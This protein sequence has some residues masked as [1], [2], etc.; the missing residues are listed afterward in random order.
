[1]KLLLVGTCQMDP[2]VD[3]CREAGISADHALMGFKKHDVFRTP[4]PSETYSACVLGFALRYAI[5][6]AS[7]INNELIFWRLDSTGKDNLKTRLL[8][9]LELKITEA[10]S[11][12]RST[13]VIVLSFIEPSRCYVGDFLQHDV[14][15]DFSEFVHQL[16]IGIAEI[17][18]RLPNTFYVD[19]NPSI[20]AI[21]RLGAQSDALSASTHASFIGDW[22]YDSDSKRIVE[23]VRPSAHFDTSDRAFRY[24][25]HLLRR[26]TNSIKSFE[27]QTVKLIIVDLDDTLWRG[28]A[29][30]DDYDTV[31]RREGWPLGFVE[32]L[33]V[34]K[35]RGGLLAICSKNEHDETLRRFKKIW[36]NVISVDDFISVKISWRPKSETISEILIEAN[37]LPENVVYVDDNPREIDEVLSRFGNLRTL[38]FNHYAWRSSIL[39]DS[40]FLTPRITD[41]SKR[42]TSLLKNK[43]ERDASANTGNREDW[44]LSLS[45]TQRI[46]PLLETH[47]PQFTRALELLNKTNQFNTTGRRWTEAEINDFISTGGHLL[48]TWLRDRNGDNGL[49]GLA[50][51]KENIIVQ[52]V[53]SC[54]VFGLDV[55]INLVRSACQRILRSFDLALGVISDTEKNFASRDIFIR[56]GFELQ[57]NGLYASTSPASAPRWI[58]LTES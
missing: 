6:E 14:E 13:P 48:A 20:E 19:V 5:E 33:L 8:N 56:C 25:Q 45:L 2:L 27:G 28:I 21:G 50:L 7:E 16:N 36:G 43:I 11:A 35:A 55:E 9:L 42:R 39:F 29:A 4:G 40:A 1:M 49:I 31:M 44:L 37:L 53:L 32:A 58:N 47:T 52:I 22:D 18:R 23:P 15:Y 24:G 30:E 26:I 17:T 34:F 57:D 12:L 41:E 10:N 46:E 38:G 3:A 54:R 51:I